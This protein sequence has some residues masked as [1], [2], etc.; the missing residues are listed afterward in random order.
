MVQA[1]THAFEHREGWLSDDAL[2]PSVGVEALLN[3]GLV[4]NCRNDTFMAI[5]EIS[6]KSGIFAAPPL[7]QSTI[8]SMMTSQKSL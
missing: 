3:G 1:M 6:I 5:D 2:P 4:S 7:S 8:S